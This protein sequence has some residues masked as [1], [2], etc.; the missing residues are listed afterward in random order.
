MDTSEWWWWL[1]L[2]V[3]SGKV[4]AR[5]VVIDVMVDVVCTEI[6][7]INTNIYDYQKKIS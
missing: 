7:N 4:V 2:V 1:L 6:I 3:V 5:V